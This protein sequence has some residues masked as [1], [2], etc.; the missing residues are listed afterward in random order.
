MFVY[1]LNALLIDMYVYVCVFVC[2]YFYLF[3]RFG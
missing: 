1:Y 2:V 3:D